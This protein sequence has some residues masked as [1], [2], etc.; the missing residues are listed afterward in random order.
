M[1]TTK[2]FKSSKYLVIASRCQSKPYLFQRGMAG[3]AFL[4]CQQWQIEWRR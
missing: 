4:E 3:S 1:S 2:P